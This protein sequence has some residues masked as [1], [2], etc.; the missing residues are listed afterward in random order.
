MKC[1][2]LQI[3]GLLKTVISTFFSLLGYA[4]F[5]QLIPT[6]S[7]YL[8]QTP[9]GNIPEIFNLS[10]SPGF[11]G[12]ER[13]SITND[14]KEI[15]FSEMKGYYPTKTP[16][17][18]KYSYSGSIWTGP[19]NLFVGFLAPSLSQTGD[20]MY[21]Q[22]GIYESFFSVKNGLKWSNPQ[23]I[24]S[25]LNSAHYFQS[26]NNG[27]YYVSTISD[28]GL[29]ANDW[30]RLL[31]KG[32]DTS[33]ISLGLPLNS[34]GDDL[35][36]FVSKDESYIIVVKNGLQISYAKSDGNWTNPKSL[37]PKINF[38][39]G[40][41]GQ[42]VSPD[43]KYLFYT[44]GTKADYSDTYIYW[45]RIDKLIDSLQH[46]NFVPYQ[47][48]A[49]PDINITVGQLFDFTIPEYTFFDDDGN[50][51]LIF[52][53]KLA[54]GNPLPNWLTFNPN[55]HAFSGI[56]NSVQSLNIKVTVIDN[57][58]AAASATFN[59]HAKSITDTKK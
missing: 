17:I 1:K 14:G 50:N 54:N 49:I 40:M 9:P 4:G 21:F 13:M 46:T 20:T 26:A 44:T 52:S 51:S 10:I 12:A 8:G 33:V 2:N 24:L 23:R 11:F 3:A 27:Q 5:A 53:A 36:F 25:N 38:G 35:D 41:W 37:G 28:P 15:Y 48:N 43:H 29:G 59:L 31:F 6:D 18:K 45:V 19:F 30:C 16:G 7:L 42:Y 58:G 22:N 57:A 55:T 39:L 32:T 47:K 34:T 56:P